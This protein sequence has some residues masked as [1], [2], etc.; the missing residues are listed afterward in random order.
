[1]WEKANQLGLV[2]RRGD[3]GGPCYRRQFVRVVYPNWGQLQW[4]WPCSLPP[5]GERDLKRPVAR[6]CV[7]RGNLNH[8][9]HVGYDNARLSEPQRIFC[10]NFFILSPHY[11][12]N[13]LASYALQCNKV[14]PVVINGEVLCLQL[15]LYHFPTHLDQRCQHL[16]PRDSPQR[17]IQYS[18]QW[19][20]YIRCCPSSQPGMVS[21]LHPQILINFL[22][23]SSSTPSS[24][25]WKYIV[26][27]GN[28]LASLLQLKA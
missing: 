20:S 27:P 3:P 6:V 25:R 28:A 5:T 18:S 24:L 26:R 16:F 13:S 14:K 1:M 15:L 22:R 17:C 19:P 2:V 11:L 10:V 21:C 23:L 12:F 4:S 8:D 9:H 7:S